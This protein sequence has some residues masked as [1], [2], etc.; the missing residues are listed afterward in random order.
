MW[1]RASLSEA[2]IDPRHVVTIGEYFAEA[3]GGSDWPVGACLFL[4]GSDLLFFSPAAIAA[5]PHLIVTCGG[6]ASPPPDRAGATMLAGRET[7]W[8][9]LPYQLH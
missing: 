3:L 4:S 1:Y 8:G 7:D 6:R 5:V 2:A 9:L